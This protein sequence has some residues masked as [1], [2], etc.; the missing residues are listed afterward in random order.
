MIIS[1]TITL[2]K[3]ISF[4]I[5]THNN[6]MLWEKKKSSRRPSCRE[7]RFHTFLHPFILS[8]SLS[9]HF[10]GR[11]KIVSLIPPR[12]TGGAERLSGNVKMC[13]CELSCREAAAASD[14]RLIRQ[15]ALTAPLPVFCASKGTENP[16]GRLLSRRRMEL[17]N[18][19]GLLKERTVSCQFIALF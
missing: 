17:R 14:R 8:P 7:S 3:K 5:L 4:L 13:F 2:N 15:R 6:Y 12:Q 10:L 19:W 16:R 9:I 18:S 1:V 11:A